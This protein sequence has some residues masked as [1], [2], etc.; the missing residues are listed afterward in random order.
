MSTYQPER[1][2][3]MKTVMKAFTTTLT[4]LVTL[5]LALVLIGAVIF[6]FVYQQ[7]CGF[8][9]DLL[10][11]SANQIYNRASGSCESPSLAI[12]NSYIQ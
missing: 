11:L 5:I 2:N 6:A 1:T 4:L 8:G 10:G 12:L 9:D 3:E 7:Q